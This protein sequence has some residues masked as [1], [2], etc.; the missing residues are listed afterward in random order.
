M[1]FAINYDGMLTAYT[2]L[3]P[4]HPF[5]NFWIRH[6]GTREIPIFWFLCESGFFYSMPIYCECVIMLIACMHVYSCKLMFICG[7]ILWYRIEDC[8]Q[9]CYIWYLV[10]CRRFDIWSFCFAVTP[11][12]LTTFHGFCHRPSRYRRSSVT[13]SIRRRRLERTNSRS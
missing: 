6:W 13:A 7:P 8:C 4:T 10:A 2:T 3:T 11:S 12:W 9:L 1:W 5:Q